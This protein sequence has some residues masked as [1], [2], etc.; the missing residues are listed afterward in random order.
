MKKL[1][2]LFAFLLL[3][4]IAY[5]GISVCEG[6]NGRVNRFELSESNPVQGCFY[7]EAAQTIT[8]EKDAEIGRA[9]V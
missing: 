3:P 4:K 2:I 8:V 7:Y 9:H 6:A 5:A 1:I